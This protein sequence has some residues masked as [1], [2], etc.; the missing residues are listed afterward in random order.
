MKRLNKVCSVLGIEDREYIPKEYVHQMNAESFSAEEITQELYDFETKDFAPEDSWYCEGCSHT[1]KVGDSYAIDGDLFFC[2]TCSKDFKTC[3]DCD[4]TYDPE[5]EHKWA[6]TCSYCRGDGFI[7]TS[8]TSA[9]YDDPAE[10]DGHDCGYC[11][12]L[13]YV[14]EGGDGY[15]AESAEDKSCECGREGSTKFCEGCRYDKCEKCFEEM[16]VE[17]R[18][19]DGQDKTPDG[20]WCEYC[21]GGEK[22]I[23]HEATIPEFDWAVMEPEERPYSKEDFRGLSAEETKSLWKQYPIVTGVGIAGLSSLIYSW[24]KKR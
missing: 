2:A 15:G 8:Y 1:F 21:D 10:G 13:G 6:K 12:G 3:D 18:H 4:E 7:L 24:L 23:C 5:G 22:Y 19:C 14:C 16:G 9:S 11:D 20:K 17:C